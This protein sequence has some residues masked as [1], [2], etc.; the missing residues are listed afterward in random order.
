MLSVVRKRISSVFDARF[1]EVDLRGRP[2]QAPPLL[3][4][5]CGILWPNTCA[6]LTRYMADNAQCTSKCR[7]AYPNLDS[8][9][10]FG[11]AFQIGPHFLN[12]GTLICKHSQQTPVNISTT[13]ILNMELHRQFTHIDYPI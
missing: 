11:S 3:H 12:Q 13:H 10:E 8:H 1:K 4:R 2:L 6:K 9:S 5:A 7:H